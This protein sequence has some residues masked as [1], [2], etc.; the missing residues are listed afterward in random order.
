MH[1]IYISSHL[2]DVVLSCGGMVWEQIQAGHEV[3]IWTICAGDPPPGDFFPFARELHEKWET[4]ADA[5]ALRRLEDQAACQQVGASY[6]HFDIP[7][8]IYRSLPDGTPLIPEGD[9]LWKPLPAAEVEHSRLLAEKLLSLLPADA[10]IVSPCAVGRHID[11]RFTRSAVEATGLPLLYYV[12]YPYISFE[13]VE[14]S[15]WMDDLVPAYDFGV[16][17]G[18]LSAW[19]NGI[20]CYKSQLSSFWDTPEQMTAAITAYLAGGGGEHLFAQRAIG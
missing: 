20:A 3:E 17:L 12:D 10:Q 15:P 16:T 13:G 7:D 1:W 2:D 18:G 19:L 4:G 11:H 8:C 14:T 5:P 6:R 9:D